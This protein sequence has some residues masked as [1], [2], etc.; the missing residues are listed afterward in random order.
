MHVWTEL[1]NKDDKGLLIILQGP[2]LGRVGIDEQNRRPS[3]VV[4]GEID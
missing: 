3:M 2:F 4:I 1:N